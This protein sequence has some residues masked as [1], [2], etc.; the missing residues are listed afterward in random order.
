MLDNCKYSNFG[1]LACTEEDFIVED[2]EPLLN[3]MDALE[4]VIN[5]VVRIFDTNML[6]EEP[7]DSPHER[8]F[9][10]VWKRAL[11]DMR[12]GE[13]KRTINIIKRCLSRIMRAIGTSRRLA[14]NF[15]A[16]QLG[17]LKQRRLLNAH[18]TSLDIATFLELRRSDI[19]VSPVVTFIE[20][21]GPFCILKRT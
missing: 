20:Y 6:L 3:D 17:V 8:A 7:S 19:G 15:I 11:K 2:S 14:K 12:R 16:A 1:H 13:P 18:G 10:D 21:F 9:K 5:S 4:Q